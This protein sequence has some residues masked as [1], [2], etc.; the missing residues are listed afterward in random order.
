[1]YLDIIQTGG[2]IIIVILVVAAIGL[3]FFFERLITLTIIRSSLRKGTDN[4]FLDSLDS[5]IG[6][7]RSGKIDEV[8][9]FIGHETEKLHRN[10]RII[11]TCAA[12]SPLLGLLGTT[13]GMI[14]IFNSIE[15]AEN[16]KYVQDLSNGIGEALY[17]TIAGLIVAI[18]LT[19]FLNI[20]KEMITNI[21]HEITDEY[22]GITES[23]KGNPGS[24]KKPT[25]I[26]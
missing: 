24:G 13:T 18:T 6:R 12:I 26:I 15:K 9:E 22:I 7:L 17:T 8:A 5:K 23:N 2:P 3:F 11:S 1:M 25:G 21:R 16:L 4:S 19:V 14:K 10:F 20:L